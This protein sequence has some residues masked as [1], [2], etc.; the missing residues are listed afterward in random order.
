MTCPA[1][2]VRQSDDGEVCYSAMTRTDDSLLALW[3]FRLGDGR[4][5]LAANGLCIDALNIYASPAP[6]DLATLLRTLGHEAAAGAVLALARTAREAAA[7]GARGK[8]G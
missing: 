5:L 3:L 6:E 2:C 8:S 4:V 1:W 7:L